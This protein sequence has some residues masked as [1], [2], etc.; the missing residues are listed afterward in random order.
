MAHNVI[1]LGP[2]G[3]AGGTATPGGYNQGKLQGAKGNFSGNIPGI[4]QP[5]LRGGTQKAGDG[6]TQGTAF[7]AQPKRGNGGT[8]GDLRGGSAAV[9]KGYN[10][11][12]QK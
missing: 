1:K 5:D 4:T 9:A 12:S 3:G 10:Q 11:G 8:V 2:C 7:A 6:H